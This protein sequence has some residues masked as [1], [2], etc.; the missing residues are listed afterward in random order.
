MNHRDLAATVRDAIAAVGAAS[1]SDLSRAR[2]ALAELAEVATAALLG[3]R[4]VVP[5]VELAVRR[6]A[7]VVPVVPAAIEQ[8]LASVLAEPPRFDET[9]D[10][11]FRRKE[12]ELGA[13]F[14]DLAPLEARALHRPL[15]MP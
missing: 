12:N 10:A 14:S 11:A 6:V 8:R 9:I 5:R 13:A 4:A 15:A 3:T 7:S 1:P 2:S